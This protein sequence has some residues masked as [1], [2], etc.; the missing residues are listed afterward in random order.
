MVTITKFQFGVKILSFLIE[1][2]NL[3]LENKLYVYDCMVVVF[4]KSFRVQVNFYLN[5]I[6]V[7]LFVFFRFL[8]K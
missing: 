7:A 1:T 3:S 5:T 2:Q 8:N 4:N 6:N